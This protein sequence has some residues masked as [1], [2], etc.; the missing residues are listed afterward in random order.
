MKVE[1]KEIIDIL[2]R[3][4]VIPV[5]AKVIEYE[6][7]Y[8]GAYGKG[9]GCQNPNC[10][11]KKNEGKTKKTPVGRFF[12]YVDENGEKPAIKTRI[13]FYCDNCKTAQVY[14]QTLNNELKEY[15][16]YKNKGFR[17][18]KAITS[19]EYLMDKKFYEMT[20]RGFNKKKYISKEQKEIF[21][22][23]FNITDDYFE[24]P[25]VKE[26]ISDD[27]KK[28]LEKLRDRIKEKKKIQ[29]EED[30]KKEIQ[31]ATFLVR[32]GVNDCIKHNHKI[33][34]IKAK[35]GLLIEKEQ[36]EILFDAY[37]CEDCL[38]N[39]IENSTFN[40][41]NKAGKILVPIISRKTYESRKMLDQNSLSVQSKLSLAGY[42]VQA[43]VDYDDDYRRELLKNLIDIKVSS[44]KEVVNLLKFC[45]QTHKNQPKFSNA[46]EKWKKDLKAIEDYEEDNV[47]QVKR[48]IKI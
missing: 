6:G 40:K 43:Q 25:D 2:K 38:A 22:K 26:E 8:L 47:I 21:K 34:E 42:N 18:L 39:F 24:T 36:V 45:I 30:S 17:Y 12:K 35:A 33:K 20:E 15:A 41:I 44:T 29:E 23:Q 31:T 14:L 5:G 28:E 37:Y 27:R 13:C 1:T 3:D 32:G 10:S 9:H 7:K 19:S 46:I 4:M 11:S 16:D 48:I